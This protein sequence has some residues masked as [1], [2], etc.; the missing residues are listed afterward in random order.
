MRRLAVLAVTVAALSA[1]AVPQASAV[2]LLGVRVDIEVDMSTG[3]ACGVVADNLTNANY[4]AALTATGVE[5]TVA[6]SGVILDAVTG[7]GNPARL[8]TT[9]G[10]TPPL[11]RT[12]EYTLEWT[13]VLGTTGSLTKT[14]VWIGF[15]GSCTAS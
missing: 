10:L 1:A 12:I 13:S 3:A 15:L 7:G 9:G 14:C 5:S 6:A 11:Y 4:T 2:E 8:C